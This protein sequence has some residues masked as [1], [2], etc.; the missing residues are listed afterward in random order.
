M[1]F[2]LLLIL[3]S[4][5]FIQKIFSQT[6]FRKGFIVTN[7]LDTINGYIDYR[8]GS[9]KYKICAFKLSKNQN[10]KSY[11][12][13]DIIAYR[14]LNDTYFVAKKITG[15]DGMQESVFFEVLVK[16]KVTLYK[17]Q[18]AFYVEKEDKKFHKLINKRL[19]VEQGGKEFYKNSNKYIGILTILLTDCKN[20][21]G[22]INKLLLSE[23]ELTKLIEFYNNC[24]DGSSISFKESKPWFNSHFGLMLGLNS[25]K[26]NF[27]SDYQGFNQ[28]TSGFDPS[29]SI[30][31]GVFIEMSSPRLH[32]RIAFNF[33]LFYLNTNYRSISLNKNG[34]ITD[35][36]DVSIEVEQLK[37]PIAFKYT[38][39]TKKFTPYFNLGI[40]NTIHLNSSSKWVQ[41]R[42]IYN[43]VDTTI[44]EA[45]EIGDSQFGFWGG[46]GIKKSISNK[47]TGF[48]EI[49]YERTSG[50][51]IGGPSAIINDKVANFQLLIGINI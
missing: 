28:L 35:R 21:K 3:V 27:Y 30:L 33:G 39:P 4:I 51:S 36:N 6:D 18:G 48:L 23:K 49:R 17:Y 50:I 8:E 14:F 10:V 19:I 7:E 2:K 31:P 42:E 41:E 34:G 25:S 40:S 26:I 47:L 11:S 13:N 9:R 38:F 5:V 22:K 37:I 46:V 32:E 29:N 44:R 16:G 43:I 15:D 45:V 12:P 20:I 1:K 24:F